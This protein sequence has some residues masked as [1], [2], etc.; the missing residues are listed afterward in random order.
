MLIVGDSKEK[1]KD[2]ASDSVD[3]VFTDP[4][5]GISFMGK[6]W[7]KALPDVEIW[8]QCLRVLKP[9]CFAFIM[10]GTRADCLWRILRDVEEAGFNIGYTINLHMY[11]SGFPKAMSIGKAI[12]KKL[13]C[14]RE[15]GKKLYTTGTHEGSNWRGGKYEKQDVFDQSNPV[16][17]LACKMEGSYAGFQ[18]K[19]ACECVITAMKPLT[20]KGYLAQAMKDGRGVSWLDDCRVPFEEF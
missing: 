7:D 8:R 11:K 16:H 18:V 2:I 17:P 6:Q 13:G 3:M 20:E 9:G 12:D 5:Y 1:L 14:E 10:S 4:P 19:P 15:K